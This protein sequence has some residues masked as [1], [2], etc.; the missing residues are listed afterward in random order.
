MFSAT[1]IEG[2]VIHVATLVVV[3]VIAPLHLVFPLVRRNRASGY[4]RSYNSDTRILLVRIK[5]KIQYKEL[6]KLFENYYRSS[7]SCFFSFSRESHSVQ[8]NKDQ[9]QMGIFERIFPMVVF[10]PILRLSLQKHIFWVI[11]FGD[12]NHIKKYYDHAVLLN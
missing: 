7:C 3:V 10:F 5:S 4:C 12:R 1:Y 6:R 2:G 8:K 9:I 11:F